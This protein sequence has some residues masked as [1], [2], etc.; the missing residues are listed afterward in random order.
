MP[1]IS[2]R[3]GRKSERGVLGFFNKA[4]VMRFVMH[5]LYFTVKTHSVP[6]PAR[7]LLPKLPFLQLPFVMLSTPR[8]RHH[9][10]TL[11]NNTGVKT[12]QTRARTHT[13]TRARA[14]R[15]MRTHPRTHRH[16]HTHTHTHQAAGEVTRDR[17]MDRGTLNGWVEGW[18]TLGWL[19]GGMRDG[20][21]EG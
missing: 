17:W 14:Y 7:T 8:R 6:L 13:H 16:A 9:L 3:R 1:D 10:F 4:L 2:V 11:W 5:W 20:W 18:F 15:N 12:K 19:D 21:L